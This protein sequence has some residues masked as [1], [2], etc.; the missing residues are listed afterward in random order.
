MK[1]QKAGLGRRHKLYI[2]AG[3][4]H[5]FV[6]IFGFSLTFNRDLRFK[7]HDAMLIGH[8]VI[9][10]HSFTFQKILILIYHV[11]QILPKMKTRKLTMLTHTTSNLVMEKAK[12][13]RF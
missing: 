11:A 7:Q 5:K 2:P 13:K 9:S 10:L 4:I 1:T 12:Q 3:R 8:Y 6:C